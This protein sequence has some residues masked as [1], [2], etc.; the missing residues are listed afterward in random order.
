M[1]KLVLTVK[2]LKISFRKEGVWTPVVKNVSFELASGQ[3]LGIV[4]ESGSGKSVS[5]LTLLGLLPKH[6]SRVDQGEAFFTSAEGERIE[7]LERS[8]ENTALRGREIGMIFQEPMTSL[9]PVF[10]CGEQMLETITKHLKM[11]SAEAKKI[12]IKWFEDVELPDPERAFKSYPHQLSGGQRQRV[13]IAMAMCCNPRLLIADEPTTALDVTVQKRVLDLISKL[14]EKHHTAVIFISHDLGVVKHVADELLVMKRG[15]VKE[16]GRAQSLFETPTS[17]YTRGLINC[18]P[19]NTPKDRALLTVEDSMNGV[20]QHPKRPDVAASSEVL[21]EVKE[22]K[23]HYTSKSGLLKRITHTVKAVD[24]V[25]FSI[26]K[27]ETMGLVGESGCGKSTLSKIISGLLDA[28]SGELW[29]EGKNISDYTQSQWKALRGKIQFIFQDPYS[30]LNPRH[31]IRKVIEEVLAMHR[32]EL[33]R[34][35]REKKCLELIIDVGLDAE[36]L[37]KYP[38]QF[39]GGQR[40]RVVIARALAADPVFVI[41]DESVSALDVS[42]QAQ[43]L[44]LMNDLKAKYQLTYLFISH[45]LS[46]V[47]YMSDRLLVMKSG[48]VVEQG[49]SSE[50]YASPKHEYT[51]ELLSSVY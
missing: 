28:D 5:S 14:Q 47:N 20:T 49:N 37:D 39:S 45:D 48:S 7:L 41:A 1:S 44:N 6:I 8:E 13:M 38:H 33:S 35:E 42:V 3:T 27:G 29:F 46:V 2:N 30:A 11:S 51:R 40:Q 21:L 23:K 36:S 22:L 24:D 15:E 43:V 12:A 50:I 25:S 26:K 16:S 31:S 17:A 10:R 34:E 18:K 19:E 4:G 9:N 32:S